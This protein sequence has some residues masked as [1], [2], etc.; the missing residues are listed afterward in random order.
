MN[1]KIYFLLFVLVNIN[2]VNA[3][4][5]YPLWEKTIPGQ[6]KSDEVKEYATGGT[7]EEILRVHQVTEP[8]LKAY[9]PSKLLANGAAVVICQGADTASLQ[10]TM[11]AIKSRNG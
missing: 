11:K 4:E 5:E 7:A 3:Q 1:Q 10:S 6:I 9:L 8:T 2:L